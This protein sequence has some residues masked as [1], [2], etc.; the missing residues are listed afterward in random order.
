MIL[1]V[2]I[3][4]FHLPKQPKT[5]VVLVIYYVLICF[6]YKWNHLIRF[7]ITNHAKP[8]EQLVSGERWGWIEMI[9][10]KSLMLSNKFCKYKTIIKLMFKISKEH[11]EQ[12][13]KEIWTD[14]EEDHPLVNYI[15]VCE[16]ENGPV[17]IWLVVWN[18][19]LFFHISGMSSSQLTF[20]PSFCRGVGLNHQPV[21]IDK[22]YYSRSSTI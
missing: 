18:I 9:P 13:L 14:I 4:V 8:S 7:V 20:T 19:F 11:F 22:P 12:K 3:E 5:K 16:L 21:I 1:E 17:E 2:R 15:T 6:I 10:K